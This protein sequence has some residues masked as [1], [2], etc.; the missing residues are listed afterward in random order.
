VSL[1]TAALWAVTAATAATLVGCAGP[2]DLNV[3]NDGETDV[4]VSVAG[5]HLK[6]DAGGGGAILGTGC[7]R[8]VVVEVPNS[9]A[10][11]LA[12]PICPKDRIWIHDGRVEVDKGEY[13]AR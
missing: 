2:G 5:E 1:R 12:G 8:D 4:T 7:V 3:Q 10:V 13:T 6:V 11:T 9:D